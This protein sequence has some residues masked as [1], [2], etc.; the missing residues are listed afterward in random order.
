MHE[1]RLGGLFSVKTGLGGFGGRV[2]S[3]QRDGISALNCI[4]PPPSSQPSN[5]NLNLVFYL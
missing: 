3:T 5:L 4:A 2:A 1:E